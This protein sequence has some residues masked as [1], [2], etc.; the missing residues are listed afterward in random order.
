MQK[1][2]YVTDHFEELM[3]EA[4]RIINIVNEYL[5]KVT[6]FNIDEKELVNLFKEINDIKE[7]ANCS[8]ILNT[9][10]EISEPIRHNIFENFAGHSLKLVV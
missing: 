3:E 5:G 4:N 7:I 6:E 9:I 8:N 1:M 2:Y 10:K